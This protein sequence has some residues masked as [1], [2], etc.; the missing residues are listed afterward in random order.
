VIVG[1]HQ[2][3]LARA[4]SEMASERRGA[5]TEPLERRAR[6]F[7]IAHADQRVVDTGDVVCHPRPLQGAISFGTPTLGIEIPGCGKRRKPQ[8][9]RRQPLPW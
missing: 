6:L 5:K 9:R 4:A 2:A 7:Q 8:I 1:E 3:M